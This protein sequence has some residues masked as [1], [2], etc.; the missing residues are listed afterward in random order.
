MI[1]ADG[2]ETE[3]Y[4]VGTKDFY[5]G[6]LCRLGYERTLGMGIRPVPKWVVYPCPGLVQVSFLL[7]CILVIISQTCC[8]LYFEDHN[9]NGLQRRRQK[10]GKA[11]Y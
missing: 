6:N 1:V 2:I 4:S 8:C 11:A 7:C 3:K 5:A 9:F 10:V